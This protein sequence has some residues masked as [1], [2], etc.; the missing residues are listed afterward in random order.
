[1]LQKVLVFTA[2][3]FLSAAAAYGPHP[4]SDNLM[5]YPENFEPEIRYI[6]GPPGKPGP[7]GRAGVR[8]VAGGAG[9]PGP[10]GQ[11]TC[12]YKCPTGYYTSSRNYGGAEHIWCIKMK[13]TTTKYTMNLFGNLDIECKKDGAVLTGFQNH[14]EYMAVY[15]NFKSN[16]PWIST[17]KP[18]VII[19][20]RRK[21]SCPKITT[22]CSNT[23]G[24][25]WTDGVTSG[26]VLFETPGFF[27]NREPNPDVGKKMC[28][29]VWTKDNKLY[30]YK[31]SDWDY[32]PAKLFMCGKLAPCVF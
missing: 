9:P 23:Q 7:P 28:F 32:R 3:V 4:P 5:Y 31:C 6:R 27:A 15:N 2:T 24:N 25:Q 30:S 26:T 21:D 13:G 17:V 10:A 18:M 22:A 20:A 19:G 12:Q 1:M 16:F 11:S 8:G 14:T 29:G